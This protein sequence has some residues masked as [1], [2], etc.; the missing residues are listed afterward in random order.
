VK[1]ERR[2]VW[3][4][5]ETTANATWIDF[6]RISTAIVLALITDAEKDRPTCS[7]SLYSY[8]QRSNKVREDGI[9]LIQTC[10]NIYYVGARI[11]VLLW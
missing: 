2:L 4:A 3:Y 7:P 11:R 5:P 10:K 1:Y 9:N 6:C 8:V